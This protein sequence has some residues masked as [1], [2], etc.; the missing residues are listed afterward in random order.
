MVDS[1]RTPDATGERLELAE[2]LLREAVF[3][4][5]ARQAAG[6]NPL[7]APATCGLGERVEP[8]LDL[9]LSPRAGELSDRLFGPEPRSPE[10]VRE[11]LAEW[12]ERQDALDRKRNHFLKDFRQR[13]GFDRSAYAPEL[14]RAFEEGLER[15]N[16][17]ESA[18]RR[19][20]ARLLLG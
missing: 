4:S 6:A 14:A 2:E 12:V 1:T 13:H 17:Q 11:V 18:E 15:I 10:R 8:A 7:A 20:L 16:V 19:E 3:A 5:R 9:L